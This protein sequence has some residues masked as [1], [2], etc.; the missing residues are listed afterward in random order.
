MADY[1]RLSSR[2]PP[3]RETLSFIV[4]PACSGAGQP[5]LGIR[6]ERRLNQ[7]RSRPGGVADE[8]EY[9]L[10]HAHAPA[11]RILAAIAATLTC[12]L[13]LPGLAAAHGHGHGHGH[14]QTVNTMTRNLY[15]GAD[16]TPAIEAGTPAELGAANGQIL[17]E[18]VHN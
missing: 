4:R 11:R 14:G 8:E 13:L 6:R 7:I 1:F 17:R 12:A 10:S 2:L 15:L 9:T 3:G 18:V 5:R 16:L